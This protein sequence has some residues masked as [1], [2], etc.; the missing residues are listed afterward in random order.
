MIHLGVCRALLC[1]T[2]SD[3]VLR[4]HQVFVD[5]DLN[6]PEELERLQDLGIDVEKL[7]VTGVLGNHT[8]TRTLGDYYIKIGYKDID[9]LQ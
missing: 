8:Y 1:K 5:H 3:G 6:N 2:D 4:V 9:T 7:R